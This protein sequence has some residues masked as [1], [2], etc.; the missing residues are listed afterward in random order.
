M[1]EVLEKAEW[2]SAQPD[3]LR[4][5]LKKNEKHISNEE[6]RAIGSRLRQR[7]Y[8]AVDANTQE[9]VEY[10][11]TDLP[12][13]FC[14]LPQRIL[15]HRAIFERAFRAH[16]FDALAVLIRHGSE[17]TVINYNFYMAHLFLSLCFDQMKLEEISAVIEQADDGS[18]VWFL[19][20]ELFNGEQLPPCVFLAMEEKLDLALWNVLAGADGAPSSD[21][22]LTAGLDI[23][24]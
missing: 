4:R 8:S 19:V 10:L 7:L 18:V 5:L 11:M 13:G 2:L 21:S 15:A 20:R 16:S 17:E 14:R 3:D 9:V 1:S 12:V 6:K 22:P 24:L 23:S